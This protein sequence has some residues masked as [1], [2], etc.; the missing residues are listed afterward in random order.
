[1]HVLYIKCLLLFSILLTFNHNLQLL[2]LLE[3][4]GVQIQTI[5]NPVHAHLC[6]VQPCFR[7]QFPTLVVYPYTRGTTLRWR[8]KHCLY[9]HCLKQLLSQSL[10]WW[11]IPTLVGLTHC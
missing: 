9:R 10:R 8:Y 1:M 2:I 5:Q 4:A 6:S 11:Y 7:N 3:A